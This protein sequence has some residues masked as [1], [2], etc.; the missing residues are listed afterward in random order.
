MILCADDFALNHPTSEGI[1]NLLRERRINAVSALTVAPCWKKRAKDLLPFLKT[2]QV[3]LHLSL[4][5][6]KPFSMRERSLSNLAVQA[7]LRLLNR[8]QIILEIKKQ[9]ESF[10]Q[11][12]GRLPDY[13]DGHEFCHHFPVVRS[14]LIEVAEFFSFKKN[15]IY[16]RVFRPENLPREKD[17]FTL[18]FL[19]FIASLPSK[20]LSQ[21]LRH[22]GIDSNNRLLGF[23]PTELNP[24]KYFEYYL[25]ARPQDKDI[26]FCHPGLPSNDLSDPLRNFRPKIYNF[27]MSPSFD[28]L[29]KKYKLSLTKK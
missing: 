13:L 23:H 14:A 24:E 18:R 7:F 6:P 25:S 15:H 26:F 22:R 21:L 17:F 3:G 28:Q 29:M 12:L 16:I 1:L 5:H 10:Q 8:K 20:K 19:N 4:T 11:G 2:T 27:L 9:I